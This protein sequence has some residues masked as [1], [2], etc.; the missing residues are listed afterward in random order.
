MT[1]NSSFYIKFFAPVVPET[2]AALMQ[3][4]DSKIKQ[5]AT[6]LGLLISTPG[7]D[8]FQGLSV[9][10]YLKGIPLEIVT[11]NFGSADSIGVVL[12]CAGSR[13]LSV[14]HARFLLHGV[15]CRFPQ[16]MSLEEKQLEEKLKGLQIDMGNIARVIADTVAKDKQQV[17]DDMLNRTTLYP[18]EAVEYGL[19]HEIQSKLF[20]PGAEV[21]SIQVAPKATV[22]RSDGSQN[23][24]SDWTG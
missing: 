24:A 20:E 5:G 16:P 1:S 17:I 19:V 12:F 23:V 6:R 11:H 8:V 4:V 22:K 21:I 3:V 15:Q 9:Y 10:N 7:G 18:E 13:R 2:V 14:P